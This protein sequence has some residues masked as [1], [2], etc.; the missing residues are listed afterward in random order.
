M[1]ETKKY[2][3]EISKAT[4]YFVFRNGP[5]KDLYNQGKITDEEIKEIQCYMQNHLAYLYNV[6]LEENNLQK[7]QLVMG[8]MKSFYVN[9][10]SEIK[11]DDD[12][13]DNIFKSLFESSSMKSDIKIK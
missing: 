7:F 3:D 4:S 8:S 11:M 9:D 12:G 13:F 2:L 6:L 1:S 10:Q 5:I